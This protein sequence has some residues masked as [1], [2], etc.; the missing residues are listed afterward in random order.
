M[1]L[2]LYLTGHLVAFRLLRGSCHWL[3]TER[4]IFLYHALGA[5]LLVAYQLMRAGAAGWPAE[6]APTLITTISLHGIYSV[7]FLELWS[8]AQ[9]GYS[10]AILKTYEAPAIGSRADQIWTLEAMGDQKREARLRGLLAAGMIGRQ[11][12][13]LYL[14]P[15]GRLAALPMRMVQLLANVTPHAGL[16]PSDVAE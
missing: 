15:S 13:T 4:G 5:L 14:S 11:A 2:L 10:L 3:R 7:T 1:T 9:G 12:D 6:A 16:R 8:L